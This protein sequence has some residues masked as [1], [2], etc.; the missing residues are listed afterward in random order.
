MAAFPTLILRD[1]HNSTVSSS[2]TPTPTK[3]P[4]KHSGG[5][6]PG[7][8]IFLIILAVVAAL[9]FG[10]FFL[11][12]R[13]RSSRGLPTTSPLDSAKGWFGKATYKIRNPRARSANAG[14]EGISAGRAGA[15]NRRNV[16]DPDEAWDSRV[17]N[18]TE[19]HGGSGYY[20]DTELQPRGGTLNDGRY[21]EAMGGQRE[22]RTGR[23]VGENPFSDEHAAPSLRSISPRPHVE[24]AA[25]PAKSGQHSPTRRSLFKEEM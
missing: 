11:Y 2:S 5:G 12:R 14:F 22:H 23:A 17:G 9:A 7:F 25:G 6:L 1:E 13:H 3:E 15:T 4:E 16:L 18:E 24:G 21:E 8:V 20:E 19:Y 10:A